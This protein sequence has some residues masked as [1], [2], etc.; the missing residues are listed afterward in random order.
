MIIAE[1][2]TEIQPAR[3]SQ[4]L[5]VSVVV[6]CF[7]LAQF[8]PEAVE[9][10]VAQTWPGWECIIVD[11]GSPDETLPAAESLM[12]KHPQAAIRL[13]SQTNQGVAEARNAGFRVAKGSLFL[14][15]DADD[16]LDPEYLERCCAR[17]REDPRLDIV[18]TD[19]QFFGSRE[20][21]F[22]FPDDAMKGLARSNTLPIAALHRRDVWQ[23]AGGFSSSL[24]GYEDWDYWL[25]AAGWG[26][27]AARIA[28]P[29]FH[30]RARPDGRQ[31]KARQELDTILKAQLV[32]AHPCQ[33]S[34][35]QYQWA[36]A[37]L[38]H[39][40]RDSDC[41]PLAGQSFAR[42][43]EIPYAGEAFA[44]LA[45]AAYWT[46]DL[47]TAL[48]MWLAALRAPELTAAGRSAVLQVVRQLGLE[49][50]LRG[51]ADT[52]N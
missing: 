10:L 52:V 15:L 46:G 43:G 24:E 17:F 16:R 32:L 45:S 27:R 30:Y 37:M 28:L 36:A 29:L 5:L 38:W 2:A 19:M 21:R 8:L 35:A 13:L 11:D 1:D 31:A 6:P 12:R 48:A 40:N 42:P 9:S 51:L 47:P 25:A 23:R 14:A 34:A 3:A 41:P 44:D 33:F 49:A 39:A 7:R 18:Y 26:A 20:G 50:P 4:A 22:A